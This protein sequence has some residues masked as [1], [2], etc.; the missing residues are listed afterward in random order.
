MPTHL[1]PVLN[2]SMSALSLLA[3]LDADAQSTAVVIA[4]PLTAANMAVVLFNPNTL[5]EHVLN[6]KIALPL[7]IISKKMKS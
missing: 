1:N 7:Q 6:V 5:T 2:I 3:C 4:H